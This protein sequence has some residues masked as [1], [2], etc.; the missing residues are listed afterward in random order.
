MNIFKNNFGSRTRRAQS[1][2][3]SY[4]FAVLT[5]FLLVSYLTE[6]YELTN[7]IAKTFGQ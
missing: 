1:K 5:A 4:S 3:P 2:R 6:L 7:F